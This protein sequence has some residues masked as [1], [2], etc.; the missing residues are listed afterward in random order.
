MALALGALVELVQGRIGRDA[1][2]DDLVRDAQG[3]LAALGF[4]MLLD[5][6]LRGSKA[7]STR[8]IRRPAAWPDRRRAAGVAADRVRPRLPGPRTELSSA[9]RLRPTTQ[10]VLLESIGRGQAAAPEAATD[11]RR[12]CPGVPCP[13]GQGASRILVGTHAPRTRAGLATLRTTGRN[14]RQPLARGACS[15]NSVSTTS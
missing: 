14:R 15:S 4:M 5:P 2:F 8:T 11:T 7:S 13:V 3:T 12:A 9:G 6:K 10:H 1:S